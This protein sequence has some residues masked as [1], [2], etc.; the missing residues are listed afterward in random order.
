MVAAQDVV[1]MLLRRMLDKKYT[2][3]ELGFVHFITL[4]PEESDPELLSACR[5]A[6]KTSVIQQN[7]SWKLPWTETVKAKQE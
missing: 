6:E 5:Q 1:Q 7:I 3:E 2:I 4:G